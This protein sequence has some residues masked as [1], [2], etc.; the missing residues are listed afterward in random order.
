MDQAEHPLDRAA[1]EVGGRS[2]L[3]S[4]LRV[5][6]AAIGNWKKRGVPIEHCPALERLTKRCVTRPQLRPDDWH[7]IWPELVEQG[8][9][10]G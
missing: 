3:A 9:A 1:R 6:P 2:Q 7:L 8:V 10:H 5:S 4:L